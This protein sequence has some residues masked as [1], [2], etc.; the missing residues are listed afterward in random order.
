MIAARCF[1]AQFAPKLAR[2]KGVLLGAKGARNYV[3]VLFIPLRW[4]KW[5]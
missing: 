2:L 3:A 4:S 5:I 1:D